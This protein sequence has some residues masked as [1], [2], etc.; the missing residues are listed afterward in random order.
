MTRSTGGDA[1]GSHLSNG[2]KSM[3]HCSSPEMMLGISKYDN[4]YYLFVSFLKLMSWLFQIYRYSSGF[5]LTF[6]FLPRQEL[7]SQK[8]DFFNRRQKE[9]AARPE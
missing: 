8:E 2:S 7:N 4:N 5:V 3:S 1:G 9:N 6:F